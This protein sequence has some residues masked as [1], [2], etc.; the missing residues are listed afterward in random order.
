MIPARHWTNK[1]IGRE[2]GHGLGYCN[3]DRCNSPMEEEKEENMNAEQQIE[4]DEMLIDRLKELKDAVDHISNEID[5]I[6][7]S[8]GGMTN[9]LD[10]I[11]DRYDEIMDYL[12]KNLERK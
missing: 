1:M 12:K 10:E 3:C 5:R 8:L 7:S 9:E 11:E 2:R 6:E 4:S